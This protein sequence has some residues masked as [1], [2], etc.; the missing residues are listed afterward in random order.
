MTA[1]NAVMGNIRSGASNFRA[2]GSLAS[3]NYKFLDRY[4]GQFNLRADGSSKFGA[5]RRWGIFPSVSV[6]WRF[7]EE[8]VFKSFKYLSQVLMKDLSLDS[9]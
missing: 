9:L 1:T 4:I 2:L 3:V 6:G 8:P 7:S 5:N